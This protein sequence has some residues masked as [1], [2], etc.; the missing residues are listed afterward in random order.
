[1]QKWRASCARVG[2]GAR[3]PAPWCL[4]HTCSFLCDFC[5]V[6]GEILCRGGG[7]A[8]RTER[9]CAQMC[10]HNLARRTRKADKCSGAAF[11][12]DVHSKLAIFARAHLPPHISCTARGRARPLQVAKSS[13]RAAGRRA[14][15]WS[16]RRRCPP[17]R[18]GSGPLGRAG[19]RRQMSSSELR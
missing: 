18:P 2:G 7:T 16:A 1:M 5:T 3:A 11:P 12:L 10:G 17:A 4:S 13:T 6:K 19:D 15:V 9:N 8:Q 14:V